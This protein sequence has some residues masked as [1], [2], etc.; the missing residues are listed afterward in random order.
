MS[1]F[2]SRIPPRAPQAVRSRSLG[3][4]WPCQFLK[5]PWFWVTLAV[6]RTGQVFCRR[7][8]SSYFSAVFSDLSEVMGLGQEDPRGNVPFPY[9]LSR[10][11]AI[12]MIYRYWYCPRSPGWGYAYHVSPLLSDYFS[13]ILVLW[14]ELTECSPFLGVGDV[15]HLMEAEVSA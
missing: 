14:E 12:N 9:I 13:S 10:I 5:W 11:H 8:L 7:T 6:W 3:R 15:L 2:W 1:F 4:P